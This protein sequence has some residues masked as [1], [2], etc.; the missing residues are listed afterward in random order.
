MTEVTFNNL[1]ISEEHIEALKELDIKKPTPVQQKAIPLI[2][3]GHNVMAQSKTGTG[4]TYAYLIPIIERLTNS[5]NE[6]LIIVPVRELAKQVKK[7]IKDLN[8]KVKTLTIYGGTSINRQINKLRQGVNIIVGTPGR[9]I[10]LYKR[11]HL[12]LNNLQFVV[13][14]EADRLLDMGFLPDIKYILDKIHSDYQFM[15]FSATLDYELRE[16]VKK[17]T[18]SDF[19]YLDLS[20]DEMSVENTLQFY[21]LIE[22][23]KQ[24]YN[25]FRKIIKRERPESALVFVNTKKTGNWLYNRIKKD[26]L[27]Y[28]VGYISGDLTQKQREETLRRFRRDRINL[29]VATDVAARGFDIEDITHVINYDLPKYPENYVHRI[30]RTSRMN[31]R[32]VAITLCLK[33][34]YEYLCRI[35]GLINKEIRRK[36]FKPSPQHQRTRGFPFRQM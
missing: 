23:Y 28:R 4:K 15:L 18:K 35:E 26:R 7:F 31:K 2:L 33:S 17:Y 16:L 12:K 21:Y 30:G 22:H 10:D 5:N 24:K 3:K 32:G 1:N 14:D 29:L 34:E 27:G 8:K 19:K 13:L 36:S 20:R 25:T 6:C 9:L 11:R